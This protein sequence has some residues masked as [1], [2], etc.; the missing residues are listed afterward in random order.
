[1]RCRQQPHGQQQLVHRRQRTTTLTTRDDAWFDE[2]FAEAPIM[3]ILRGLGAARSVELAE[4][5]WGLGIR[6]VEVPLQFC[7]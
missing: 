7:S 4:R 2:A 6:M 3:V 1:M 5:A